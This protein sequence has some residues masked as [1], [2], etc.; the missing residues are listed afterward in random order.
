MIFIQQTRRQIWRWRCRPSTRRAS[1]MT[2][3]TLDSSLHFKQPV[4][5]RITGS[6]VSSACKS[7][8]KPPSKVQP[9]PAVLRSTM[10][11]YCIIGVYG[12][13]LLLSVATKFFIAVSLSTKFVVMFV[14][15]LSHSRCINFTTLVYYCSTC[16]WWR[17]TVATGKNVGLGR[18]TFAVARSTFSWWV[19]TYVG[20][21]RWRSANQVNSTFHPLGIDEWVV[22]CN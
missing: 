21:V 1:R 8:S 3:L 22:S 13:R 18:R 4:A 17:G 2:H 6:K 7:S 5:L 12:R 9:V 10:S 14:T 19:T 15:V 16:S 20:T 11:N